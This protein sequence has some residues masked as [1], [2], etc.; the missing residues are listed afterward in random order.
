MERLVVLC[1]PFYILEIST[2]KNLKIFVIIS[3]G[4]LAL[5]LIMPKICKKKMINELMVNFI[6]KFI[7]KRCIIF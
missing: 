4:C 7:C 1:W 2:Q 5:N 3:L 6:E